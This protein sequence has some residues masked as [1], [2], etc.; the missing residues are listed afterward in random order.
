MAVR[1]SFAIEDKNINSTST[2]V[3][4]KPENYSDIDLTLDTKPSGDIFKKTDAAAV[5]QSIRT[6]LL[7]NYG[8]KPFDFFFGANLNSYL[9][10]LNDPSYT[11]EIQKD[12]KLAIQNYEP[13]AEVLDVQVN[14]NIDANDLKITV[15]FRI[16]STEEVVVLT[17]SLTRIK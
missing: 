17:T 15:Q 5:K 7:T 12:V 9:F 3:A 1:R 14:N 2:I 13:R 8:E 4:S 11:K 16:I 6:I 10:E